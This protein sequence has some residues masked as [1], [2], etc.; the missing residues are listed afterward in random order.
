MHDHDAVRLDEEGRR[1]VAVLASE[2]GVAPSEVVGLLID[3]AYEV[4]VRERRRRAAR[5]IAALEVEDV[6]DP[7]VLARQLDGAYLGK[8]RS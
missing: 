1:R 8:M 3:D 5:G 2:R 7:E 6:P 4:L